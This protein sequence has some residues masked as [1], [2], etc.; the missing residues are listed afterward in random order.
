MMGLLH[1]HLSEHLEAVFEGKNK[2]LQLFLCYYAI[3]SDYEIKKN[4]KNYY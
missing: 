4:L 2:V 1:K 3:G